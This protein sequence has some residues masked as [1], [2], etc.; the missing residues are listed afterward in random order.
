MPVQLVTP[1]IPMGMVTPEMTEMQGLWMMLAKLAGTVQ[2]QRYGKS[3][4]VYQQGKA[5][6]ADCAQPDPD[7]AP[8]SQCL[9]RTQQVAL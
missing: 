2:E 8:V 6:Q 3:P 5:D 9:E 7:S 1:G 4:A